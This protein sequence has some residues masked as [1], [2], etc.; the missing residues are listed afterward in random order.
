MEPI[1]NLEDL[2][3]LCRALNSSGARYLIVGG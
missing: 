3:G 1:V 2:V